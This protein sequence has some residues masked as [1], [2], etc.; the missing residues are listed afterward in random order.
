MPERSEF[1][2]FEIEKSVKI[3][4]ERRSFMQFKTFLKAYRLY[5]V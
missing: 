3:R 2:Y 1:F 4:E 5:I